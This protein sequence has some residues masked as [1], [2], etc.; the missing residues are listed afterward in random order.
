MNLFTLHYSRS[1]NTA[2]FLLFWP[3]F[4]QINAVND[5][6]FLFDIW[7]KLIILSGLLIFS[8]AVYQLIVRSTKC[9]CN[10]LCTAS[11]VRSVRLL[12][13][14]HYDC[15]AI[16]L[17]MSLRHWICCLM[18]LHCWHST[19][20]LCFPLCAQNCENNI[21]HT[22]LLKEKR[23]VL[24]KYPPW[25]TVVH[26]TQRKKNKNIHSHNCTGRMVWKEAFG[27]IAEKKKKEKKRE[28]GREN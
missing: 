2:C 26:S 18:L 3:V 19:P 27:V 11:N 20:F 16:T 15:W 12:L 13:V 22:P 21:Y 7:E 23:F 14:T 6:I 17:K 28:R 8:R 5:N 25:Y 1:E 24:Q 10:F 4:L 9:C